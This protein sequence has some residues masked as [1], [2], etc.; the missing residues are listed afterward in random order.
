MKALHGSPAGIILALGVIGFN[1]TAPAAPPRTP[2]IP[3]A[4]L[5]AAIDLPLAPLGQPSPE[6][7]A[8]FDLALNAHRQRARRDDVS[9]LASFTRR[10]PRSPWVASARLVIAHCQLRHGW[11]A[12]GERELTAAW[13]LARNETA[14][15]TKPLA[16]HIAGLLARTRVRLGR[17]A[18]AGALLAEL[19]DRP[20]SGPRYH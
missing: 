12:A 14:G 8:A 13:S 3:P 9:A 5:S 10:F 11:Y 18:D 15:A 19:A 20:L 16:D 17:M 7:T 4:A 6:E 2:G 1:A